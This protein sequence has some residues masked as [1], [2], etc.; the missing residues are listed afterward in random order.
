MTI[1]TCL[2]LALAGAITLPQSQPASPEAIRAEDVQRAGRMLG[3]EFDGEEIALMLGGLA[4]QR[5]DFEVLRAEEVAN[6]LA[7]VLSFTPTLEALARRGGAPR[8]LGPDAARPIELPEVR[9]P[10]DLES[11]RYADIAT[12]AAL[13]RSR[14]VSCL[15]LAEL[16]LARLE[17]L[18]SELHC[19]VTLLPERARAQAR[20][21][22]EELARGEWRGPL[23]GIPWGAKDLLAVAGAPT[24][25][26]ATP[27][28]EQVLAADAAV[29][30]RLDAAGAVL[31]AK[32]TLG[33]LAWGDVWFGGTTRN[34]WK[35]EQGSSGSSAG[36]ASATAAGGV[37][38]AIGSETCGSI[39]S[40]SARCG[41]SSLRPTF[42]RVSRHGAM[43]LSW[44]MDKLGPMCRSLQDAGIVYA[45]IAGA[46]ARD[47]ETTTRPAFDP[48]PASVGDL[49]VG[50]VEGSFG[51]EADEAELLRSL[52]ALGCDLI[53]VEMPETPANAMFFVLSVEAACAFDELTRSGRD[54]E[55][56]RQV[57]QAWPNVFRTARF[58][59]AVEYLRA[60]R[61]RRDLIAEIEGLFGEV[62]VL[63]HPTQAHLVALNLSGHPSVCAPWTLREDGT[64]RSVAFSAGLYQEEG[65]LALAGA[66]QRSGDHHRVHPALEVPAS[67]D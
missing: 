8:L 5:A 9:R 42:G 63:V 36:P 66:W 37:V 49:R 32:L 13:I 48:G 15:E 44:S 26:G 53:P 51:G 35:P 54:D 4:E 43:A 16:H 55:L 65:L 28:R 50:F 14:E 3:L 58:V 40:P 38:F 61:V 24:T 64:P 7:P 19:V 18:D 2:A 6:S 52:E 25:W 23:H 29:V 10:E 22:D 20:A 12:L 17:R 33:A 46:D 21:L 11:L 41:N 62:D 45:A 31:V 47:E 27:Y 60:N 39:L 34:P 67:R 59:P 1:A 57:E 56:V 30:E